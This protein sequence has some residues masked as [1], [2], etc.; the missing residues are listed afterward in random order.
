MYSLY[1]FV[2]RFELP[3]FKIVNADKY[4]CYHILWKDSSI[5]LNNTGHIHN[6]LIQI[7]NIILQ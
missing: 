5:N 2:E 3:F 6:L 4:D 1:K 7:K